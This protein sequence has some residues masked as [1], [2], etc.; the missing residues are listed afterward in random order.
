[1]A[2]TTAIPSIVRFA[3]PTLPAA[4]PP[5]AKRY[6]QDQQT[7]IDKFVRDVNAALVKAGATPPL[8][9]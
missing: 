7:A 1:M 8:K 9:G 2:G 5:E 3:H 6:L 4:L